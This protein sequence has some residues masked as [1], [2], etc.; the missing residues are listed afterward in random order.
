MNR[1]NIIQTYRQ[2]RVVPYVF[3][4]LLCLLIVAPTHSFSNNNNNN[5]NKPNIVATLSMGCT[6]F[7]GLITGIVSSSPNRT[8]RMCVCVSSVLY[9]V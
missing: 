3:V 2:L 5:N 9:S 4:M 8:M 1:C 7:D 6:L